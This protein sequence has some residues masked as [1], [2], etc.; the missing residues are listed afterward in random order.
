MDKNTIIHPEWL[1]PASFQEAIKSQKEM[2]EHI[3]LSDALQKP[4]ALIAGMD[5]SNNRFDPTERIFAASVI[6]SY[7]E[8]AIRETA[9]TVEI[10]EF[11]YIPGFLGFR[12]APALMNTFKKLSLLPDVIMVDGNGINHPRRLGIASQIGILLGIPTIGVAKKILVGKTADTLGEE[13]GS[14]VPILYKKEIVAMLV[15][16]KK[17]TRARPIIVSVGHLITLETAVTLVINCIKGYKLPEPTRQAHIAANARR[18]L[19]E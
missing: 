11:P 14:R 19:K 3:V 18:T 2:A 6:L 15:R 12:E 13:V 4:P 1:Y 16:T 10:Q 7:P 9:T 5:V 17:G 8:L